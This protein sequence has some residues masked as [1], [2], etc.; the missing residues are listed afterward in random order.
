MPN[1]V[2]DDPAWTVEK[3]GNTIFS[4]EVLLTT[5]LIKTFERGVEFMVNVIVAV[6]KPNTG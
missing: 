2:V 1:E 5:F 6:C 4:I 3:D